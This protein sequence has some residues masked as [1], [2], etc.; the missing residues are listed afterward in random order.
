[1]MEEQRAAQNWPNGSYPHLFNNGVLAIRPNAANLPRVTVY[2]E[3]GLMNSAM[4]IV[5]ILKAHEGQEDDLETLLRG[6][7]AP[8]R[9]EP[10][11]LRYDLWR[12]TGAA[13]QFILDELYR[14]RDA[15]AAHKATAHFKAY[16]ERI[17]DLASRT[18]VTVTAVD[19]A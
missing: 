17:N 18:A 19:V 16:L 11:N 6:M 1:M 13:G 15:I 3:G 2:R 8:S 7:I 12:D 9:A 5:A 4:K 10:G 14:D